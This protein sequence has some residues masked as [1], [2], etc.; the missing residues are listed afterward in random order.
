MNTTTFSPKIYPQT[1]KATKTLSVSA[2]FAQLR[3][4]ADASRVKAY[5]LD[6]EALALVLLI[7][8]LIAGTVFYVDFQPRLYART[9]QTQNSA[10]VKSAEA[11]IQQR[12]DDKLP[13]PIAMEAASGMGS[14]AP[15][16]PPAAS[17]PADQPAG[18]ISTV[19]GDDQLVHRKGIRH[20]HHRR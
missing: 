18:L 13:P 14:T 7:L 2:G 3:S 4:L 16:P 20:H 6:H 17:D 19:E 10:V 5:I 12:I 9:E 8:F 1:E 15:N 11:Q